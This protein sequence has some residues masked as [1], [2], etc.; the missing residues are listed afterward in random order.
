MLVYLIQQNYQILLSF[1]VIK[2]ESDKLDSRV[3]T[4]FQSC[5]KQ[6]QEWRA[7]NFEEIKKEYSKLFENADEKV[8][9]A[10]QLYDLVSSF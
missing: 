7:E 10:N 3:E 8:Q 9:I 5:K 4:F 1:F 6:K 2:D